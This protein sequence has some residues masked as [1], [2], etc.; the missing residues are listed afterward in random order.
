[1]SA[2]DHV[3]A[4]RAIMDIKDAANYLGVSRSHLSHILA[5]RV[6]SVPIIPR[7][8]AGRRALIRRAAIDRWLTQQEQGNPPRE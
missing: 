6:R 7:V 2:G 4:D 1:V 5:G 3:F 8:R